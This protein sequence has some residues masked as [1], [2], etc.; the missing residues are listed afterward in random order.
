MHELGE[1]VTKTHVDLVHDQ[2]KLEKEMFH[3]GC[4]HK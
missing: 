1:E 2:V 3:H 4:H